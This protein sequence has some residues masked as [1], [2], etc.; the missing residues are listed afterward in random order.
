[1]SVS[2]LF[3][4]EI[5]SVGVTTERFGLAGLAGLGLT[6]LAFRGY[7]PILGPADYL[8]PFCLYGPSVRPI[9]AFLWALLGSVQGTE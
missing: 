4:L 1:M 3:P 6:G 2:I 5:L 8:V 7:R 9:R